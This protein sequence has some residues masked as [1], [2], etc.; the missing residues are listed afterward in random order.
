M[1]I[2]DMV[3]EKILKELET[4]TVP[5]RRPWIAE[6]GRNGLPINWQTKK[7]YRGINTLLLNPGEYLT[8]KQAQGAGGHVKAGEH[9]HKII[10]WTMIDRE[11]E[12]ADGEREK[13]PLLRYYT[14]FEVS[15]CEGIIRRYPPEDPKGKDPF[16]PIEKAEEIISMYTDP[17][18]IVH[19]NGDGAFYLPQ[20]DRVQVPAKESFSSPHGYYST[21]FHE[22]THSTGHKRRLDRPGI[23]DNQGFGSDSYAFEELVAELGAAFLSGTA[24]IDQTTIPNS[25]AYIDGWSKQ[26]R[27]EKTW[28]VRAAGQAQKAADYIQGI[29]YGE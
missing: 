14:V 9:G 28:M 23:T 22:L 13:F 5:W 16:T 15:Q 27:Q 1:N 12:G 26:L 3:T 24:G 10:F 4:G 20:R 19:E 29:Q 7:P 2:Y 17:P 11:R 21:L 25:A 8:Y 18:E 6:G